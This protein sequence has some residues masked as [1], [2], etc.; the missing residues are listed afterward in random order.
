MKLMFH[1][2]FHGSPYRYRARADV[3]FAGGAVAGDTGRCTQPQAA[4]CLAEG[5]APAQ[6]AERLNE[7]AAR[8]IWYGK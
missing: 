1:P 8:I 3:V 5:Y 7:Q 6:V 4:K 2:A